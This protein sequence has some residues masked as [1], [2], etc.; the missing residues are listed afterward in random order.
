MLIACPAF[1]FV[2]RRAVFGPWHPPCVN[3]WEPKNWYW[4]PQFEGA[5]N[6]CL[7]TSGGRCYFQMN[8]GGGK[9]LSRTPLT[10]PP[11]IRLSAFVIF[12][13][14]EKCHFATVSQS[15]PME[16]SHDLIFK[17]SLWVFKISKSVH[18][19]TSRHVSSR[20]ID[21]YKINTFRKNVAYGCLPL[22]GSN[23]QCWTKPFQ[24]LV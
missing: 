18:N 7:R 5:Q 17:H 13:F 2:R 9:T 10:M 8:G 22:Y 11:H 19:F 3:L 4:S 23:V 1:H 12:H 21:W 15:L 24:V 16:I 6:C 20:R 14:L